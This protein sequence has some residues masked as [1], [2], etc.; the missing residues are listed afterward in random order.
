MRERQR[1][2]ERE[3]AERDMREFAWAIELGLWAEGLGVS[4]L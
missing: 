4:Y 1:Q 2:R 3:S